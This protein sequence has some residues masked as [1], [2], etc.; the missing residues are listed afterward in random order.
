MNHRVV[1]NGTPLDRSFDNLAL[2][3]RRAG[4]SP[5]LFGYTD[6]AVDPRDT[7]GAHDPRLQSYEGVL[8]GFDSVLDLTGRHTPWVDWLA[9]RGVD[10]GVGLSVLLSTE[11]ERDE[12][13]SLSKFMTDRYFDWL[14]DQQQGWFCHLSY[15]RPHSPYSAA[16][17]FSKM[18]DPEDMALPI[19]PADNRH[20]LHEFVLEFR[21]TKAPTDE[22]KMRTMK[23]QYLG[24]ISE[25]DSQLGHLWEVLRARGEWDNTVIIV[26]SDHGEMLGDHGL[27]QKVGYFE[28]SYHIP[29]VMRAPIADLKHGAVVDHFTENVDIMPTLCDVLA[30]DT[31]QQ[32]DGRSLRPFLTGD[33]V[34]RW[35][36]AASWEF[37]WSGSLIS[38]DDPEWVWSSALT[39]CSLA[40]RRNETHAFVQF[41][42]GDFLCFDLASDPTWRTYEK[43]LQVALRLSSEMNAWRMQHNAHEFTGFLVQNGGVGRW[44]DGV[45][46]RN[47]R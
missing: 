29:C 10:V 41:A 20:P 38:R 12:A 2:T 19:S 40:V 18:Y 16:G 4:Y 27:I 24:M 9:T 11:N 7:V 43:D 6:Q 39:R 3:A 31:P 28:Q 26:T 30:I 47:A 36:T 42:D 22:Q 5:A 17:S 45:P 37:D 14:D 8:P 1:A 46:W 25:V 35:R 15:L 44:P 33:V 13:L 32:C 23:A 34:E 21:E